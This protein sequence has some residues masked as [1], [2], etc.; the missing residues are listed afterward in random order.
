MVVLLLGNEWPVLLSW[1][2]SAGRR[3]AL[4]DSQQNRKGPRGN[5]ELVLPMLGPGSQS[6]VEGLEV[7]K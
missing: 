3:D 1:S 4:R 6:S 2:C 5:G 7:G